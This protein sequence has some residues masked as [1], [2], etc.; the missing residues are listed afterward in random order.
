MPVFGGTDD[1]NGMEFHALDGGAFK[2]SA[3][4]P[5]H[6]GATEYTLVTIVTD[7]S[8]SVSGF[9]KTL[10]TA[11]IDAVQACEKSPRADNLLVRLVTFNTRLQEVH[12]FKTLRQIN[13][14]QDYTRELARATISH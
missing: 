1:Q 13:P 6:L 2:F 12:G 7:I 14:Q 5:E 11:V 10:R 8:G 9:E 3:V 4:R